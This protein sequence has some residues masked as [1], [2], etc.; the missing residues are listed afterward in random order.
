MLHL[1][2][3]RS[4]F[5]DRRCLACPVRRPVI[6]AAV[7]AAISAVA[8]TLRSQSCLSQLA[9]LGLL[10]SFKFEPAEGTRRR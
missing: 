1:L 6:R 9:A 7:L 5:L 10:D 3:E 2:V 4:A 8:A